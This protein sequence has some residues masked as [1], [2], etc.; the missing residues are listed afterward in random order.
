MEKAARDAAGV[1]LRAGSFADLGQGRAHPS[2]ERRSGTVRIVGMTCQPAGLHPIRLIHG[3]SSYISH[4]I[5]PFVFFL[6]AWIEY[7][8]AERMYFMPL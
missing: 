1:H 2:G 6:R 4:I 3:R 8:E 5:F 7:P